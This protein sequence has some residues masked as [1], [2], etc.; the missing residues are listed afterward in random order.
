MN[1]HTHTKE[2]IENVEQHHK[3][4]VVCECLVSEK[5]G[6]A[7]VSNAKKPQSEQRSWITAKT[8]SFTVNT[9][10]NSYEKDITTHKSLHLILQP[11]SS[12]IS[13][14]AWLKRWISAHDI[15]MRL[16]LSFYQ[17]FRRCAIENS[18]HSQFSLTQLKQ[19][20]YVFE[21]RLV[22]YSSYGLWR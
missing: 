13:L 20:K 15:L 6:D 5:Q 17:G 3:R 11:L 12:L 4:F 1:T 22:F 9:S 19:N 2:S 7:K 18:I 14:T 16:S 8:P 21:C 10:M